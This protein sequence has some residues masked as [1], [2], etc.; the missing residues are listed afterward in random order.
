MVTTFGAEI[1]PEN[2]APLAEIPAVNVCSAVNVFDVDGITPVTAP[3]TPLNDRTPV[4]DTVNS[5]FAVVIPT[6]GPAETTTAP[7]N[8]LNVFT[9]FPRYEPALIDPVIVAAPLIPKLAALKPELTVKFPVRVENGVS[10]GLTELKI[11]IEFA[12]GSPAVVC[13]VN[14]LLTLI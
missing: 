5:L 6:P 1:G 12:P 13:S 10:P 9:R 3:V 11:K 8:P 2:V 7:V 14:L 4:F